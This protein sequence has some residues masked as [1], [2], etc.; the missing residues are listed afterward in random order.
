VRSVIVYVSVYWCRQLM[1]WRFRARAIVRVELGLR[2]EEAATIAAG[3]S[4][5]AGIPPPGASIENPLIIW[6]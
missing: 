4:I 3:L 6:C 1:S 5:I 2:P